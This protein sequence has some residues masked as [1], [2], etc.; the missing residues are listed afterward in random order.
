MNN[1]VVESPG[2]NQSTELPLLNLNGKSQ[3]K[4]RHTSKEGT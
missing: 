3:R 1:L 4:E 2:P